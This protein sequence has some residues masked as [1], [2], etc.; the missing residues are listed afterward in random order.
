MRIAVFFFAFVLVAQPLI[1][2]P[3]S[4]EILNLECH[5]ADYPSAPGW[6]LYWIDTDKGTITYAN[7]NAQGPQL[8]TMA[9]TPVQITPEAYNFRLSM[10]QVT[11]D[12]MTGVNRWFGPPVQIFNCVKGTTPLPAPKL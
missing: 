8:E 3:A 9:T 4:A 11:I 10:G 6:L 12:R 5:V 2:S 7:A 1:V